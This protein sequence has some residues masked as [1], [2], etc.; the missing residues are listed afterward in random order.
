VVV[1]RAGRHARQ[2]DRIAVPGG[3][4]RAPDRLDPLPRG[5]PA[6][7]LADHERRRPDCRPPVRALARS[8]LVSTYDVTVRSAG[9]R[10]R[11]IVQAVFAGL[12]TLA[13]LS[14]V[15][16][17]GIVIGSVV[18]KGASSLSLDFFTQ[19]RGLFGEPGG[20]AEAIV[21]SI[22]IV[23]IATLIAVP[24]GVL[25]AIYLSEFASK[26]IGTFVRVV[27]DVMNGIPAIV[28][29]IFVFGVIVVGRGQSALAGAF[30]LSILMV[31]L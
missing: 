11:R 16:M 9:L 3:G 7:D 5:D 22:V 21:G 20:I 1:V 12:A 28:V 26:R 2:P 14:A 10:R 23:A 27:L 25:V 17:L 30:A 4:E 6:R 8:D 29:G 31:P 15:A 19:P 24:I 13:A 18:S